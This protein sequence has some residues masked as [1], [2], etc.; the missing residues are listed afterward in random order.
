VRRIFIALAAGVALADASIVTLGLPSILVELNATVDG[1][2][3]VL[4]VYTAVLALALLPAAWLCRRYG[5]AHVGAAGLALFCAAPLGCGASDSLVPLLVLRGV[6]ALGGAAGLVAAFELLDGGRPGPGRRMWVAASVFGIAVGPALG[7][8]LTQAFSW[9][10]IFLAQ[11]PTVLPG[12]LVALQ[13]ARGEIVVPDD[14]RDPDRPTARLPFRKAAAL[15]LLSASLTAVIFLVVLLLVSGWSIEPLAAA[16]AVSVLPIAAVLSSRMR[17]DPETR[18]IAGCLLVAGGV[19]CLALLPAASAWWTV[20]PQVLAGAGMG[21]ALPALSG[22]LM[23]ERTRHDVARLLSIRH[24]GIALALAALAPLISANLTTTIDSAREQGTA[25]VLDAPL[26]PQDKIAIAPDL[27]GGLNTDD[28]R[29][30]LQKSIAKARSDLDPSQASELDD[31]GHRLD[32]VVTGAVRSAFRTTFIVTSGLA[33]LAALIL[34]SGALGA[35]AVIARRTVAAAAAAAIAAAAG[36]GI[37]FAA[38]NQETVPI[39]DPC[40]ERQLPET[41]GISGALQDASLAALDRAACNFGSSREELLLAL[42]DDRLQHK[43]E[44]E[45]GV[46]PRSVFSLGPALLGL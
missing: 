21:M 43:F 6:Q 45:H 42:F 19:G 18:A 32:D 28:P 40:Q 25:A 31:L 37:V 7:G 26:P 23:P 24:A 44:Q 36:Y 8:A 41:G 11:A 20:V 1:V 27:F 34:L 3:L 10:A 12:L 5:D 38:S 15:A 9:R 4:G 14:G 39:R 17:W 16:L 46:N 29:G 30:E 35:A 13:A 33:L 2:A 22:E